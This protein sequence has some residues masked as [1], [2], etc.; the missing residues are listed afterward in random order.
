MLK[1]DDGFFVARAAGGFDEEL[2]PGPAIL[3]EQYPPPIR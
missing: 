3:I 2:T 1:L